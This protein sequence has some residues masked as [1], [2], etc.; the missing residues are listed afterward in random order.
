MWN[1]VRQVQGQFDLIVNFA[2]DWLPFYHNAFFDIRPLLTS[3]VWVL[4]VMQWMT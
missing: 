2:Y 3:S 1:Y 4:S